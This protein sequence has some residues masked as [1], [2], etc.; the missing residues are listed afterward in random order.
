MLKLKRSTNVF[1]SRQTLCPGYSV[2]YFIFLYKAF[3]VLKWDYASSVDFSVFLYKHINKRE[4]NKH[5]QI[6]R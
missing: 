3:G 4:E 2:E 5:L 6:Y 1:V